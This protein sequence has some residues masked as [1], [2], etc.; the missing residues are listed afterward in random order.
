MRMKSHM[1][2]CIG[3][4]VS[5]FIYELIERRNTLGN[6][7]MKWKQLILYMEYHTFI[8]LSL[9]ADF[10]AN[11]LSFGVITAYYSIMS[12]LGLK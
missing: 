8:I 11:K 4:L 1:N 2:I 5:D 7:V 10:H 12:S 3:K 6:K 9:T